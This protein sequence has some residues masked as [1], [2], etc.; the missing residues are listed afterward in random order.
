MYNGREEKNLELDLGDQ[1][2]CVLIKEK[3]TKEI[4]KEPLEVLSWN[5]VEE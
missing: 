4:Y 5:P 1:S 2:F 3:L